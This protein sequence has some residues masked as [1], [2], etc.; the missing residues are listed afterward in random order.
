MIPGN[1]IA[2]PIRDHSGVTRGLI[3][4]NAM[5]GN[6]LVILNVRFLLTLDRT[7]SIHPGNIIVFVLSNPQTSRKA[8]VTPYCEYMFEEDCCSHA[9]PSSA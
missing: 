8:T 2:S 7:V 9:D 6:Y 4:P 1:N 5:W 3:A